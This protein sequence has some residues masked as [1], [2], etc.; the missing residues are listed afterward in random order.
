MRA[1][2][3]Q[4]EVTY[5]AG[6]A[7]YSVDPVSSA[8]IIHLLEGQCSALVED[9]LGLEALVLIVSVGTHAAL[10]GLEVVVAELLEDVLSGGVLV[11][12][13]EENDS[14]VDEGRLLLGSTEHVDHI[15]HRHGDCLFF[16][17]QI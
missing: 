4:G 7:G 11:L 9:A 15:F 6:Q 8:C 10:E 14:V 1:G 3:V 17:N 2:T 12:S 16:S 13:G 5:S